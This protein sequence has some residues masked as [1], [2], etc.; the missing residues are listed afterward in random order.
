MRV[1][2]EE[3]DVARRQES[4]TNGVYPIKQINLLIIY[5]YIYIYIS[6][7]EYMNYISIPT[8][9]IHHLSEIWE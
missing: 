8:K 4:G 2:L 9:Y 6:F 3:G 1:A 7:I 5:T